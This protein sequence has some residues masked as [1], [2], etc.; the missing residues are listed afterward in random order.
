VDFGL[1]EEQLVLEHSL[2]R[3]LTEEAPVERVR[4]WVAECPGADNGSWTKLAELG[5][6]GILVSEEHGGSGLGMFDAALAAESLAWALTPAPFLGSAVMAAVALGEGADAEQQ[7]RWLPRIATGECRVG[8]A[9]MELTGAREGAGVEERDGQ[10]HGKA[11]MVIDA[12]GADAH[13]VPLGAE[14]ESLA[15][16][17]AHAPGLSCTPLDTIDPTRGFAEIVF[18]D[19]E[20]AEWIGGRG[21]MA[22]T[23]AR[24]LDAGRIALAADL[25]GA[26]ERAIELA[27]AYAGQREQFG[28]LIGSFQAVKHMCAEMIAELEPARSLVWYA[29]HAFDELPE[30]APLLAAHAKAHLS[31]IAR[32][33][34]RTATEVHGGIG[35][36]AEQN[37]HCWFKRAGVDR[38]LLGGPNDLRERAARVQGW[39]TA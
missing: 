29:A 3:F 33:I 27:V 7:G 38:Q 32:D 18:A 24:M 12:I 37:L 16:V 15:L 17:D 9:A 20:P 35:F 34:V 36:T 25:L 1:S 6:A 39:I 2:R 23:S 10:L 19:V 30:E 8:V 13:L 28:R 5:I 11:L 31:E 4:E 14:G 26:S 22:S 21:A